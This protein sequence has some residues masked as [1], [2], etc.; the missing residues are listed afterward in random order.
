MAEIC[1]RTRR[2]GWNRRSNEIIA[3][4]M[5]KRQQTR[6]NVRKVQP[7][8]AVRTAVLNDILANSLRDWRPGFRPI[9]PNAAELLA[10]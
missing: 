5:A 4:R 6:W 10:A 1:T 2:L 7:L 3:E 9:D 8:L